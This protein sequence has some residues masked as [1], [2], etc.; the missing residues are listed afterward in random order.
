MNVIFL[1]I[2]YIIIYLHYDINN[3]LYIKYI[4][5]DVLFY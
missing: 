2:I 1:F 4:V 3:D 5:K